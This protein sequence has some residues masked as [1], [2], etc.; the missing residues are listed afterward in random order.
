MAGDRIRI[1]GRT[2]SFEA[3]DKIKQSVAKSALF[4]NVSTGNVKKGAD[5]L[6]SFNLTMQVALDGASAAVGMVEEKR[7]K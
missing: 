7:K 5:N 6:I 1:E 3:V 4:Q 2:T